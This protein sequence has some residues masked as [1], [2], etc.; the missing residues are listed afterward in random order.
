MELNL[1]YGKSGSGKSSYIYEN[2]KKNLENNKIFLIVPEQ[3]NLSTEKKLFEILEKETLINVEV[4]TLKRMAYRVINE[5]GKQNKLLLSKVGK[6]LLIYDL[7]NK[8][9]N[10]LNFLSKNNNNVELIAKTI[11]EFKKH[12]I[13]PETLENKP[14]EDEY[15]YLK[16]QDMHIIYKD[17]Q[18]KISEKYIDENDDLSILSNNLDNVDIFKN[19]LIYI[20]EFMGFTP[21]ELKVFE[22]LLLQAKA[23]TVSICANNLEIKNKENDVFYFNKKFAHKII[24]IANENAINIKIKKIGENEKFKTEEMKLLE[25]NFSNTKFNNFEKVPKNIEVFLADNPN[26]ELEYVANYILNLV[27]KG[28]RYNQIAI[29]TSNLEKYDIDAKIVFE[30][31]NIPLY[32]D[33]KKQLTQNILVRYLISILDIFSNNWL[34][35]SVMNYAKTGLVDISKEDI[36]N[37]E[38]Y[39]NKWGITKKKFLKEFIYEEV[40]NNQEKIEETR[41]F[42]INP[43]KSLNDNINQNKNVK[44][45][46][47][48]IYNFIIENNILDKLNEKL[49]YINSLEITNEYNTSYK[50]LIELF[51]QIIDLFGEEKISFEKYK[52]LLQIGLTSTMVGTIPATQDQVIIGQMDRARFSD[53]KVCFILGVNDGEFPIR[54]STE[55]YFNDKDRQILA[56]NGIE[57][58]KNSIDTLYEDEFNVYKTLTIP[59]EKLIMSYSSS[60]SLGNNLRPSTL[61]KKIKRIFPRIEQKSDIINKN[62]DITN[63]VATFDEALKQYYLLING[64]EISDKWKQIIRYYQIKE[65]EKFEKAILAINFSNKSEKITDENLKKL[66]GNNLKASISKLEEY[67]K[68]P[69]SY[70]MK[71]GLNLK[72]KKEFKIQTIDTGN[73]MHEIIDG[74]FAYIDENGLN[75]HILEEEK[76]INIVEEILNKTLGISKYYILSSSAKFRSLTKKLKK[77][78]LESIKYIVYT[79]QNSKFEVLEHE[80]EFGRGKKYPAIMIDN[81]NGTT[82]ELTGKID[83]IDIGKIDGKEYLRIIDYKSSIKNIDMNK[84]VNGL[85][86]QLITYMESINRI[87]NTNSA[88]ILYMNLIDNIIKSSKNKTEEEIKEEIKKNFRMQGL[89]VANVNI[90]KNMDTVLDIGSSNIIPVTLKKDGSIS[91]SKSSTVTEEQFES[92]QKQVIKIIKQISREILKGQIEIKPFKYK[93]TTGCDFCKFKSICMFDN[94]DKTCEYNYIK[95]ESKEDILYKIKS[96]N[97]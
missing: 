53:I 88:G 22:K 32:I 8:Q 74:F 33:V 18:D 2:I 34:I 85:Q 29:V 64:N 28:Y 96:S 61:L 62:I 72:E 52:E 71:Y 58:A 12:N 21:Q 14:I 60:D 59:E 97:N 76:I 41:K 91:E 25:E 57:M 38:N 68:C 89:I 42:L 70:H 26:S 65:K 9:K 66:Y 7:L 54:L 17:Y 47:T 67:K 69:F 80:A 24:E 83:R 95:E 16:L 19:S 94:N 37:F 75:I 93:K 3:S 73:F 15:T 10:K 27:K 63:K 30:K 31:Y 79:L 55:G 20:D 11:T 45:I 13:F 48:N 36:Y 56:I 78:V 4:L 23:V 6:N 86:I 50:L 43:L 40:N 46:T 87:K 51:E 44:T 35:D 39:C 90:L 82:T 1:I 5:I 49:K 81:E 77:V 92:L 84:V